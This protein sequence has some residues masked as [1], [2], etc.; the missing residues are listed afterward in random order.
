MMISYQ[1]NFKPFGQRLK[2]SKN[3]ELNASLV[4]D[5]KYIKSKIEYGDKF[6]TNFC[7]L[8]VPEDDTV[9]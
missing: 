2:T 7:S 8:N 9:P 4:Y 1:K 5:D 3:I 6:Y